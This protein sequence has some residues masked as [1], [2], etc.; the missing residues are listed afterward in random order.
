LLFRLRATDSVS[1]ISRKTLKQL[2]AHFGVSDT[3]VVHYAL[4]KLAEDVLPSYE[5]DDGPLTEEQI[6]RI[7]AAVAQ[8]EPVKVLSSLFDD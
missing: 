2:A 7:H 8:N 6:A 5:P 1:G 4:R 3:Q